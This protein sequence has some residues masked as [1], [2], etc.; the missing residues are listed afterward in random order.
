M[1][2][3]AGLI[4]PRQGVARGIRGR[5]GSVTYLVGGPVRAGDLIR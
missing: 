1:S 2:E 4:T 3:S 5:A